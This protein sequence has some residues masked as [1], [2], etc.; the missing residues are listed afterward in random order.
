MCN[1]VHITARVS[2]LHCTGAGAGIRTQARAGPRGATGRVPRSR[3]SGL[4]L[5]KDYGLGLRLEQGLV[6]VRTVGLGLRSELELRVWV[7]AGARVGTS[8]II[9]R[10]SLSQ[11]FAAIDTA[12]SCTTCAV[13]PVIRA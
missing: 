8:V 10:S 6:G 2:P 12:D 11:C 5:Q 3:G 7:A 9:A 1:D 13:A 4:G